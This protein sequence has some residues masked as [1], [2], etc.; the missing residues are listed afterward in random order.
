L[1]KLQWLR[2]VAEG[3]LRSELDCAPLASLPQTEGV[4]VL[5]A[6]PGIGPFSAELILARGAG[7]PDIFP[8]HEPLFHE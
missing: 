7:N 5:R 2:E 3:A 8:L 4:N 6:L 1:Q